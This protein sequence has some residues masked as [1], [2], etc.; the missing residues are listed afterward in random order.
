[1][2]NTDH[3]RTNAMLIIVTPPEVDQPLDI[4]PGE[5]AEIHVTNIVEVYDTNTGDLIGEAHSGGSKPLILKGV[6]GLRS[7]LTTR[8]A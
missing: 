1:M 5:I 3:E 7:V 8:T 2:A 4:L 6:E